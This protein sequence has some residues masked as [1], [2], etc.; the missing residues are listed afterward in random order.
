LQA[1][2]V[3]CYSAHF[4]TSSLQG[5]DLDNEISQHS[6]SFLIEKS[7]NCKSKNMAEIS[8]DEGKEVEMYIKHTILFNEHPSIKGAHLLVCKTVPI[9]YFFYL[10]LRFDPI[11]I[12]R[13]KL[14]YRMKILFLL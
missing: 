10:K 13:P 14:H 4:A 8:E 9:L 6:S 1:K 7:A 5:C 3:P 11:E 12:I 2:I